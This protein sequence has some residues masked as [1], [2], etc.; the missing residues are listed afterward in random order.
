[1]ANQITGD[2]GIIKLYDG[3]IV[4][5]DTVQYS[6]DGLTNWE[7]PP[8]NPNVHINTITGVGTLEGHRYRRVRLANTTQYQLPEYI[9]A[10]DGRTVEY[11]ENAEYLTWKYTDE[12]TTAWRNWILKDT[13]KGTQGEQGIP[14][15]GLQIAG[16]FAFDN[17]P[18]CNSS[19]IGTIG[20]TTCTQT[21]SNTINGSGIYVSIG[22][23]ILND[24]DDTGTWWSNT[25]LTWTSYLPAHAGLHAVYWGGTTNAGVGAYTAFGVNVVQA[26]TN[27]LDTTGIAYVCVD[28]R[29]VRYVN[30]AA[31]DHKIAETNASTNIGELDTFVTDY[32]AATITGTGTIGIEAGKLEVIDESLTAEKLDQTIFKD[33]LTQT[34]TEILVN[35]SDIVGFGT[36]EDT[37]GTGL[38]NNIAVDP[39]QLVGNGLQVE[40][41]GS[42]GNNLFIIKTDDL[43]S[44]NNGL[45]SRLPTTGES[46]DLTHKDL[47]VKEG[48]GILVDAVG[49]SV[50]AD[51]TSIKAYGLS[52]I[53]VAD[54]NGTT[55]GILAKHL[56]PNVA[57]TNKGIKKGAGLTDPLEIKVDTLNADSSIGFNGSGELYIPNDGVQGKQLN[58]NVADN[59]KGII[60][61]NQQLSV[62]VDDV[63]VGID[64]GTGKLYVKDLGTTTV[65]GITDNDSSP[66]L[67]GQV[68]FVNTASTPTHPIGM[69]AIASNVNNS[70]TITT[71]VDNTN[72]DTY[73]SS[74][75]FTKTTSPATVAFVDITGDPYDNANLHVALDEKVTLDDTYGNMRIV[76]GNNGGV[77]IQLG[78]GSFCRLMAD[79][80]G[81]MYLDTQNPL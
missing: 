27:G 66:V 15:T 20:C 78:N 14:G 65:T 8:F 51:E 32:G 11:G 26:S 56:N 24:T 79:A 34:T 47:F 13:I 9:Y 33:G 5:I 71:Y 64:G 53:K 31:N 76:S 38:N 43:I 22:N 16:Y 52:D 23:H 28:S 35:T 36:K 12:D 50:S 74:L 29:W 57:D 2:N 81:N 30:L 46:A 3:T 44:V 59:T 17:K 63:T 25:G 73:I 55:D 80:N 42:Y 49:V 48:N 18:I 40:A 69:S 10:T 68:K 77:Y 67:A 60:L 37:D 58:S 39:V 19:I 62:L 54:N 6:H 1:M 72:M 61:S 70:M 7:N 45:T 41:T 4:Y 75:G 21:S